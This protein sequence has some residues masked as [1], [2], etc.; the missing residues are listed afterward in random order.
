MANSIRKLDRTNRLRLTRIS[1]FHE[2]GVL[3]KDARLRLKVTWHR[4]SAEEGEF[5]Y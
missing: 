4:G 5:P 3:F 1:S 2:A